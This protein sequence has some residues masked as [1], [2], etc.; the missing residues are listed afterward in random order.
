DRDAFHLVRSRDRLHVPVGRRLPRSDQT[1]LRHF[2]EHAELRF[3]PHGRVHLRAAKRRTRLEELSGRREVVCTILA[4]IA[5]GK[6]GSESFLRLPPRPPNSCSPHGP[7][8][9]PFQT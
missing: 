7:P 9:R 3:H 4:A 6:R 2:L 5:R 1:E 8:P